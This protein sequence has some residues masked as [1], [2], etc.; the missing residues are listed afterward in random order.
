MILQKINSEALDCGGYA[1]ATHRTWGSV[2]GAETE[3]WLEIRL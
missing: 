3:E 1:P 2:F